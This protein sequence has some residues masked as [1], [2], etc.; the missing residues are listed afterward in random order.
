ML[1]ESDNIENEILSNHNIGADKRFNSA[2]TASILVLASRSIRSLLGT[3]WMGISLFGKYPLV[4]AQIMH[5]FL[6]PTNVSLSLH[7]EQRR[8][9]ESFIRIQD[10]SMLVLAWA[11]HMHTTPA[12]DNAQLLLRADL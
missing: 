6:I 10:P 7:R 1:L 3:F 11:A 9:P 2:K 4:A 8:D 12:F 5:N